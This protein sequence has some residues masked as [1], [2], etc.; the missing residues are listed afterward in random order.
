MRFKIRKNFIRF[1]RRN[2]KEGEHDEHHVL[3]S[4]SRNF[5]PTLGFSL[6]FN[7]KQI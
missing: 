2:F 3:E 6:K 1:K 7:R 5:C 4:D